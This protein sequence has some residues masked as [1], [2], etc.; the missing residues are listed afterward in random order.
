MKLSKIDIR[1][2]Y[3]YKEA[4]IDLEKYNVVVGPNASGKT[5]LTRIL[6]LLKAYGQDA[7]RLDIKRLPKK[8]RLDQSASSSV[9][10]GLNFT[11]LEMK[12]LMQ[13]IFNDELN[14]EKFPEIMKS[15]CLGFYWVDT[16]SDEP[17][18]ETIFRLANGF[19]LIHSTGS[20][21]LTLLQEMPTIDKFRSEL[22]KIMEMTGA[23]GSELRTKFKERHNFEYDQLLFR[24]E[25]RQKFLSG[26]SI[27]NFFTFD[28][29]NIKIPN[30]VREVTYDYSSP[31]KHQ[32]EIFDFTGSQKSTG[33][34]IGIWYLL[35]YLFNEKIILVSEV[36]PYYS[37]LARILFDIKNTYG[38]EEHERRL[39]EG[40]S[41]IF[42][43]VSFDVRRRPAPR[44]NSTKEKRE[45]PPLVIITEGD[46][47]HYQLEDSAS[48]YF[49]VLYL[50]SSIA[51]ARDNTLIV[52]EPALHLHPTKIRELGR[53]LRDMVKNS[54]NQVV[55]ITHSPYFVDYS[56]LTEPD[57]LASSALLYVKKQQNTSQIVHKPADLEVNLKPHLFKPEIFFSRSNIIV[58]GAAD[59]A[60]LTAISDAYG[61]I[62]DKHDIFIVDAWGKGGV[63]GYLPILKAYQIV[64][65]AMVDSDYDGPRS[66][67]VIMLK[68]DLE[69]ELRNLGWDASNKRNKIHPDEAYEFVYALVKRSE[70]KQQIEQSAFWKVIKS[71]ISKIS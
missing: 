26:D 32:Q 44:E 5:N 9:L 13:V 25:F 15:A 51:N 22:A 70:A 2:L 66:G 18:P 31:K 16:I 63:K 40:F 65:V 54:N 57:Q 19:S 60:V 59:L 71:A 3:S 1:N 43:G 50:L 55:L 56:L 39:Q 23:Q 34:N 37:G 41:K 7:V 6:R 11:D 8:L 61:G 24:Q 36:R 14:T 48:G 52:D 49:E 45:L 67:D 47:G 21:N 20:E 30:M 27:D 17:Y 35:G 29:V 12:M 4:S 28:G 53:A 38:Y 69:A 64:S 62:F 33:L 10:I 58:E 42:P 46:G 68:R